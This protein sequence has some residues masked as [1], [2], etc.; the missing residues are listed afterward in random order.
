MIVVADTTPLRYLVAIDEQHVLPKLFGKIHVPPEVVEVELQ[1]GKTPEV[2][3]RWAQSP[4]DWI[5]VAAPLE[6]DDALAATL[7]RGEIA[8]I[9]L[10]QQLQAGLLLMDDWN[11][12]K[13]AKERG[14]RLAGTLAVLE[15]AAV[16]NLVD[17]ERT[18]ATLQ[19][20]NYYA[21]VEQYRAVLE[22]VRARRLGQGE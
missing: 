9:S 6:L 11:A 22:N 21:T 2:V 3:R 1:A 12:R 17:I 19:Q 4:P 20:T 13:V 7:H 5:M 16:R 10:A 18:L 15:E 14:F 8:A